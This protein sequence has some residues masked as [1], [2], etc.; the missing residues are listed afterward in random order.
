M[1]FGYPV[2]GVTSDPSKKL[3]ADF[4]SG[5]EEKIREAQVRFRSLRKRPEVAGE[6]EHIEVL[7]SLAVA[8]LQA[9]TARSRGNYV[10]NFDEFRNV[11]VA[12]GRA[13]LDYAHWLYNTVQHGVMP[14]RWHQEIEQSLSDAI[15][16]A[17]EHWWNGCPATTSAT[18]SRKAP[19]EYFLEY[20]AKNPAMTYDQ[21]VGRIGMARDTFFKIKEERAWVRE[22]AYRCTA[23]FLGC[24]PE[25][26]HPRG[27]KTPRI[28]ARKK[29][30]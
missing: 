26:L 7:A 15:G 6:A 1:I 17:E 18:V 11:L 19:K 12:Y 4:A 13:G 24:R 21:M 10:T 20:R 16:E 30:D 29:S 3:P 5:F 22:E 9:L 25:D 23:E 8:A 28:V 14:L 2:F 27:L